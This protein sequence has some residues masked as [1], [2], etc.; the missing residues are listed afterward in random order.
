MTTTLKQD[1]MPLVRF[2]KVAVEDRTESIKAGRL[3]TKD[4]DMAY[5]KQIGDRDETERDAL[6][7]IASQRGKAFGERGN[8]PTIPLD[9]FERYEKIYENYLKGFANQPD[10]FPVREWAV[11]TP[12][13]VSNMH[14]MHTFTVEQVAGWTESAMAMFG[15]GGRELREK[16]KTWLAS[17]DE[18]AAK[19]EAQEVKISTLEGTI[20]QLQESMAAM[21]AEMNEDKPQRGRPRKEVETA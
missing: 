7:W 2:G 13:Q 15:M 17:G 6:E 20:A 14:T 4:I 12:A 1:T 19:I 11:L 16:A 21:R 10:G 18:K 8:P 3:I 5:V 9:W